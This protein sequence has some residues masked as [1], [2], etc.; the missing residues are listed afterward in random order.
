MIEYC[1]SDLIL[2]YS[3]EYIIKIY[4]INEDDKFY[5]II[6]KNSDESKIAK[7]CVI[8]RKYKWNHEFVWYLNENAIDIDHLKL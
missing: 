4:F 1:N 2:E 5:I 7:F 8:K 6:I 3:W